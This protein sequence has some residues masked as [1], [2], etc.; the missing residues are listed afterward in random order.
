MTDCRRLPG[1][2]EDKEM[3]KKTQ[4][5]KKERKRQEKAKKNMQKK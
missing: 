2:E 4:P 3:A 1:I 5:V